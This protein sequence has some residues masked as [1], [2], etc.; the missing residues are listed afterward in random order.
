MEFGTCAYVEKSPETKSGPVRSERT[1]AELLMQL[2][3]VSSMDV[4][5]AMA[6]YAVTK[7]IEDR[8]DAPDSGLHGEPKEAF[9][10]LARRCGRARTGRR[11]DRA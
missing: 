2:L 5:A 8:P 1:Q 10:G 11:P 3:D 4:C 9:H 7:T 6:S